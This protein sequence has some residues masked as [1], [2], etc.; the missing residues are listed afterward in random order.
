MFDDVRGNVT[1]PIL[2]TVLWGSVG[3][4]TSKWSNLHLCYVRYIT[5][6][7]GSGNMESVGRG[8]VGRK[9]GLRL[10]SLFFFF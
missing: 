7:G 3:P 5:A 9:I 4:V 8:T 2:W 1:H 6:P 10:E